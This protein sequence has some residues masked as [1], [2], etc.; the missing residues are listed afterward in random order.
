MNELK[1]RITS[2][3]K[4]LKLLEV[5]FDDGSW[6]QIRLTTPLPKTL[7]ELEEII[8]QFSAPVEAIE[9]QVN[10][11]ADLSYI[12]N[13][14]GVERVCER[15]RLSQPATIVDTTIDPEVEAA[16]VAEEEAEFE[17]RVT[18]ILSKLGIYTQ[19]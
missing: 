2:F 10:P 5:K 17:A 3:D 9:A 14:V 7:I 15:Q 18:A 1:Y 6:A 16:L 19:P 4:E 12:S 11:D 13:I 8:K